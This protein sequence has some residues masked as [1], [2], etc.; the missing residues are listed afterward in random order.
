MIMKENKY[1]EPSFF[2]SYSE[3]PRSK[4][5]LEAAGEWHELRTMLPVLAGKKVLDLGCGF[6]WHCRYA[7]EQGAASV[8]GIDLSENMLRR[9]RELS[10]DSGIEYRRMAIEDV[11]PELGTFDVVISSLALHYVQHLA[12]VY[13]RIRECLHPGGWLV[14]STEHPIF[15]ARAEQDWHYGPQGELQH[16]PVDHYQDEGVRET[17]FLSEPVLKYHRTLATQLN[18][19]IQAGF[20][21]RRVEES[22]PSPE[23]MER[24]PGMR[25]EKRRP[26]FLM[27]AATKS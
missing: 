8:V 7:R 25:D 20:E 15:T 11:G 22:K 13:A 4:E 16:W 1:D 3:M 5:G 17:H 19:L 26:M 27:I 9:A 21:I 10:G 2:A 6:G 24:V 12:P 23:M 18:E 14:L